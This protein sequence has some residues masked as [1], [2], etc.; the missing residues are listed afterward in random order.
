MKPFFENGQ[1][2]CECGPLGHRHLCKFSQRDGPTQFRRHEQGNLGGSEAAW[3]QEIIV[4]PRDGAGSPPQIVA[5][6]NAPHF[7]A[8]SAIYR[9]HSIFQRSRIL[10]FRRTVIEPLSA[11]N[12]DYWLVKKIHSSLKRVYTHLSTP[13][14]ALS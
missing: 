5:G 7:P 1:V 9:F 3:S 12:S 8:F 6:A 11:V 2:S 14:Q 4:E 13:S 10:T